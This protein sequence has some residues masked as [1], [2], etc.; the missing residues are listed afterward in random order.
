MVTILIMSAKWAALG[1]PKL[2][3]FC[4]KG[5]DITNYIDDATI[6]IISRD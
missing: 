1:L 3:K 6:K 2:K 4:N 5:Y